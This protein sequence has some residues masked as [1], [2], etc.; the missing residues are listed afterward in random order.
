[1]SC[2]FRPAVSF[3][4][5]LVVLATLGPPRPV[6]GQALVDAASAVPVRSV[7]IDDTDWEDLA[8]LAESIGDAR[9]VVLGEATHSEGSTSR[10]KARLVRYLH[11]RMGFDVLA[12]EAGLLDAWRLNAALRGSDPIGEAATYLMRGGW[13][14]SVY[15][16][17]VFAYARETWV[18]DRPLYMAGFD[19]GRPPKG[20]ANLRAILE[21]I[22]DRAPDARPREEGDARIDRMAARVFGYMG[23]DTT[24]LSPEE[25]SARRE[26]LEAVVRR[27]ARPDA[28]VAARF[29]PGELRWLRVALRSALAD[30][31][32]HQARAAGGDLEWNRMRDSVMAERIGI[33]ADSL[34]PG[35]KIIVWAA[36]AHFVRNSATIVPLD[37]H[38]RYGLYQQAGDRVARRFGDGM[39]TIAFVAGGGAYGDLFEEGSPHA[40]GESEQLPAIA[41]GSLEAVA[42]GLERPY[43]FM[44][45]RGLPD[46]HPLRGSFV[47]HALGYLPN[48]ARWSDVIDAFFFIRRA[49]PERYHAR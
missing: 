27:L 32:I 10:A 37:A 22:Y 16:R 47:S 42:T 28:A 30:E 6:R 18:T 15:S 25:R 33:L 40:P 21:R 45:L 12:W 11:E 4:G 35:R 31:A 24:S 46:G 13:D 38:V 8:P 1:M 29:G 9:I 34:Y 14:R 44:D 48:R 17:P 39:Y 19:I 41:P 26:A 7:D 3:T 20:A 43:A 23:S 2:R 36:T 49:E 5:C